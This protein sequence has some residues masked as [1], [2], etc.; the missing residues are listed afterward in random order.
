VVLVGVL[1]G[2]VIAV[3][4][5]LAN[6]IRHVWRPYDAVLGR[7]EF[8]RG[9]HDVTRHPDA[10]LVPGLVLFRF[11][12]PLFFANADHFARR[13]REVVEQADGPVRRVVIAAE[14][15]TDIDTTAARVLRRLITDLDKAG[16]EFGVAELKGPVKDR[17]ADYGLDDLVLDRYYSTIGRAVSSYVD[18]HD[19]D[20]TDW[21]DR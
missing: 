20:W 15:I 8:R 7:V 21:S 4:L 17:L 3:A 1:N 2:I 14:P 16:I 10:R 5:S 11:D 13:V 19:V 12:A 9:Y 18:D 6:F